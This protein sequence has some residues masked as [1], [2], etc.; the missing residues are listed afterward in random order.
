MYHIAAR[1]E[2]NQRLNARCCS[3]APAMGFAASGPTARSSGCEGPGKG[4]VRFL[5]LFRTPPPQ[6]GL[7]W[8]AATNGRT[9]RLLGMDER[10]RVPR[11]FPIAAVAGILIGGCN[12][13][14]QTFTSY[15]PPQGDGGQQC[16]AQC[17]STRQT[18]RQS[19]DTLVQQCRSQAE[20]QAHLE[21]VRRVASYSIQLERDRTTGSAPELP[22]PASPNYGR[23]DHEAAGVEQQ[24]KADYDLCYQN[25]G[26]QVTYT[27]HCVANCD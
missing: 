12:P 17:S 9:P 1:I 5:V 23:C 7:K 14:Y 20:T 27:T 19:G 15:A 16:L 11:L 22:G 8:C 25:C 24:C 6:V 18:C 26:G 21:T 3:P 13:R 4:I 10:M 2:R